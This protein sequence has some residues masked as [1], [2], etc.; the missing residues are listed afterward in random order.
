MNHQLYGITALLIGLMLFMAGCQPANNT[1]AE[2]DSV[3]E[4]DPETNNEETEMDNHEGE[5]EN[6]D[7]ENNHQENSADDE[8]SIPILEMT[9]GDWSV[10]TVAENLEV[11]WSLQKSGHTFY[12]TDRDGHILEVENGDVERFE[13]ETSDPVAHEGEGGLL[14]FLL[15]DDFDE[16]KEAFAYYTYMGQSALQNRVIQVSHDNGSWQETA[17]LLDEIPGDRIHNGGR[18]AIG[19]DDYLYVTTGDANVPSLSQDEENLA[20][21]ILR[22][23]QGGEVPDDNPFDGSF[24]YSTGH[25]NPQG[26]SWASDGT[27]YSSEHGPTA[28]DEINI[29][30]PGLNYGWPEIEGDESRDGMEDPAIHSGSETWA[31]SGTAVYDDHLLVTGLRGSALYVYDEEAE[32][33]REIYGGEGRLRDVYVEDEHIYLITN[34]TDGRGD[35]AANDDRILRLSWNDE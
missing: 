3:Q 19:P 4:T 1:T 5:N 7:A 20:G 6:E 24:V 26:L 29:I 17:I 10:E 15:A 22:M 8:S 9:T 25:R 18:L 30:E 32:E 11:P 12:L 31:P 35:P 28:Q 21:K 27:M 13:L 34:N 2:P 16:S 23:T 14:G 33:L